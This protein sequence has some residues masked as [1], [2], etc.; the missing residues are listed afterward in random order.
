MTPSARRMSSR[1]CRGVSRKQVAVAVAVQAHPVAGRHDLRRERRVAQHLLPHQEER[2][3]HAAPPRGSP[4]PQGSPARGGRRRRSARTPCHW[5]C[6]PRSPT[7]RPTPTYR[8]ALPRRPRGRG[9]YSRTA[10]RAP[11]R[12]GSEPER[13]RARAARSRCRRARPRLP[14]RPPAAAEGCDH[15]EQ[16]WANWCWESWRRWGRRPSTA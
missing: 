16:A 15:R 4:G 12:C 13:S 8:A 14:P 6:T 3:P 1:A 5:R 2:R 9:V 7:C 10:T 11:G